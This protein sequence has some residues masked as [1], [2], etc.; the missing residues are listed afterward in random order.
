F[1]I[2]D[3]RY[4]IDQSQADHKIDH[5]GQLCVKIGCFGS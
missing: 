1:A 3:Y 4:G 2:T 5:L